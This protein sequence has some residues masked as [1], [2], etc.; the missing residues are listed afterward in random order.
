MSLDRTKVGTHSVTMTSVFTYTPQDPDFTETDTVT[1]SITII[2]PCETTVINDAVFSPTT[3]TVINGETGT[4]TFNEVTDSIEVLR[5]IDTLCQSR[6]YVLYMN[7]GVTPASFLTLTGPAGGPHTITAA[8]TLDAH[9][10]PW[11][12]K[13]KTTLDAYPSN[14]NNDHMTSIPVVVNGA[15]CNPAGLGWVAT[16]Q[17][18]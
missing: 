14:A 4:M 6:S 1:F 13:L 11:Q 15:S 12:F 18:T 3:L 8:P 16:P 17:V 7:D 2:D 9:E 10:G 5:N